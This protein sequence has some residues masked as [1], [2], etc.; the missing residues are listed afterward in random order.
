MIALFCAHDSDYG[1]KASLEVRGDKVSEEERK[2]RDYFNTDASPIHD[3]PHSARG[4][5]HYDREIP[6]ELILYSQLEGTERQPP[7]DED[8]AADDWKTF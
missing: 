1:K 2:K 7:G 6:A 4:V 5:L 3:H 8:T